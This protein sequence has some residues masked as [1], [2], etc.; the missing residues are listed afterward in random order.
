M[1]YN[2][3]AGTIVLSAE[4]S[5]RLRPSIFNPDPEE[6]EVRNKFWDN[7]SSNIVI[8]RNELNKTVEFKN[9]DTTGL[10]ALLKNIR[11]V[12]KRVYHYQRR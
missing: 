4:N 8:H 6:V 12:L 1:V 7:L 3:P 11:I 10:D 5:A 9:F 2:I